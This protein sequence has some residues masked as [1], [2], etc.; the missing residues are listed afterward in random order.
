M[1]KLML[2]CAALV[3]SFAFAGPKVQF[4]TNQG[5]FTLELNEEKA[6][7]TVENFLRYVEYGS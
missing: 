4:E 3:S 5:S 2:L 7:I 1:K 6:P